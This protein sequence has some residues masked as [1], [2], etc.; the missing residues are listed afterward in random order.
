MGNWSADDGHGN[1][2]CD[3][4]GLKQARAEAQRV[5]DRDGLRTIVYQTSSPDQDSPDWEPD[6][7]VEPA[8]YSAEAASAGQISGTWPEIWKFLKTL[9]DSPCVYDDHGEPCGARTAP[10][11]PRA[12]VWAHFWGSENDDGARALARITRHEPGKN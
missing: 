4:V 2:V 11:T 7:Y 12:L 10:S 9:C 6:E 5:A 1:K 3:A 8:T